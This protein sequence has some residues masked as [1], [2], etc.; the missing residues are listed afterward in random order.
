MTFS[1]L[2]ITNAKAAYSRTLYRDW[3]S[4]D[5]EVGSSYGAPVSTHMQE[6][7]ECSSHNK[8]IRQPF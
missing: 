2:V 4:V 3:Q 5:R 1:I 8:P 7:S 6:F